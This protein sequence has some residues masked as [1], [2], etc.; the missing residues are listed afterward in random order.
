MISRLIYAD[1]VEQLDRGDKIILIFGARQVGKTTLVQQLLADRGHRTLYVTGDERRT[2]DA[3]SSRDLAALNRMVAGYDVLFVDEAQRIP[4]IGIN[5]K[6]LSDNIPALR[7]VVTGSS[8]LDLASQTREA[9]TGRAWVHTLFPIATAELAMTDMPY[10]LDRTLDERLIYGMYPGLLSIVAA[11]AKRDYLQSLCDSYLYKDILD[12]ARIKHPAKLQD[13]LQLLAYQIGQEV[14]LTELATQLQISREAVESYIDLLERSFVIFRLRGY[15]RNLRKEVSKLPKIY[16][17]DLGIRN[18]LVSNFEP[19]ARRID[20]GQL[21]E[22]YLVSE[23]RKLLSYS[24]SSASLYFWRTH[25]GAEFDLIE[26]R[27]GE[28]HAYEFKWGK[29]ALRQA[30]SFQDAYPRATMTLINRDN[31]L[32]FLTQPPEAH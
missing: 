3:L 21:W 2:I 28:P 24:K 20:T 19:L 10:Q 15:S 18:T 25:T 8:A 4:E 17:W 13:L 7:I 5:L 11:R 16:F 31:Y 9:L 27:G 29:G 32:T 30:K 22:N 23:R 1:L 26:L 14:S 6:L 12:I